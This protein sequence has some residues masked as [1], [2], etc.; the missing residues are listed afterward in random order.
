MYIWFNNWIECTEGWKT[1]SNEKALERDRITSEILKN[2]G[3]ID[4][5][6]LDDIFSNVW[7]SVI[8]PNYWKPGLHGAKIKIDETIIENWQNNFITNT[9]R[10]TEW[11]Q[12]RQMLY[13][14]TRLE[15]AF[16]P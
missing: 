16:Y 12:K 11:N 15:H 6:I 14:W 13:E 8:I 7:E 9:R 4:L 1:L 10:S 3:D 2:L 5:K